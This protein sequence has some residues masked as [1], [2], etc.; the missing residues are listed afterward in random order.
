MIL[1]ISLWFDDMIGFDQTIFVKRIFAPSIELHRIL[2]S[3][4]NENE[5]NCIEIVFK[6]KLH[7]ALLCSLCCVLTVSLYRNCDCAEGNRNLIKRIS[8]SSIASYLEFRMQLCLDCTQCEITHISLYLHCIKNAA[9]S[10]M[11]LYRNCEL[12]LMWNYRWIHIV[13]PMLRA[14][15]VSLKSHLRFLVIICDEQNYLAV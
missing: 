15:L 12:Y 1:A 10:Q 7:Q 3:E 13:F 6:V 8:A 14:L 11:S 5:K 4:C 9:C 2:H